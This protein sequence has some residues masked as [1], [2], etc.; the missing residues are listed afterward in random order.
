[1][2]GI[3]CFP[4]SIWKTRNHTFCF[5]DEN[6]ASLSGFESESRIERRKSPF[7]LDKG[8]SANLHDFE[9]YVKSTYIG[10]RSLTCTQHY[11]QLTQSSSRLSQYSNQTTYTIWINLD[12]GNSFYS[13]YQVETNRGC[14]GV[15][16]D[17]NDM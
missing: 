17:D 13:F 2:A 1:M 11:E 12:K 7:Y 15:V 6:Y 5:L 16:G 14:A 10:N 4:V 9:V 3:D 8:P